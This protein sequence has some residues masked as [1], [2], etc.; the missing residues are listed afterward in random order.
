M[1]TMAIAVICVGEALGHSATVGRSSLLPWFM[2]G[3]PLRVLPH[4]RLTVRMYTQYLVELTT[5]PT[6]ASLH[7]PYKLHTRSGRT[8]LLSELK[9]IKAFKWIIPNL[10]IIHN[11]KPI[12][13]TPYVH[14]QSY[15]SIV[16]SDVQVQEIVILIIEA[17]VERNIFAAGQT[18]CKIIYKISKYFYNKFMTQKS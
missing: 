2:W 16:L 14:S 8:H 5:G 9:S 6:K 11:C 7:T 15:K 10:S 13:C 4:E 17:D 18:K 3:R 1:W 12:V